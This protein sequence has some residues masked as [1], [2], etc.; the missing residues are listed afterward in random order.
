MLPTQ[1]HRF[2]VLGVL[3]SGIGMF[4]VVFALQ[5]GQSHHWAPWIWGTLAGGVGFMAAFS[6]LAVG[7]PPTSR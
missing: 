1:K 2:D 4:M 3:L 7:Q 5:E 6:S